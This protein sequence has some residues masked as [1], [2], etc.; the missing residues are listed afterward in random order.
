M[1]Y[2]IYGK[3]SYLPWLKYF[4]YFIYSYLYLYIYF[5]NDISKG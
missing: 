1:N 4:K 3:L 5:Y 2:Y